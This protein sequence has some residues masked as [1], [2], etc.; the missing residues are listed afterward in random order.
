MIEPRWLD[1]D[2]AAAYLRLSVDG[3]RAKVRRGIIPQP[4]RALGVPRWDR[5]ALD[6]T[7]TGGAGSM[8][9]EGAADAIAAEIAAEGRKGR[10]QATR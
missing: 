7:M 2:G 3:F 1:M 9:A 6:R 8:D 10:S 4:S 5:L